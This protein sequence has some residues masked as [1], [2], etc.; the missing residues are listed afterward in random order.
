MGAV[1]QAP[2]GGHICLS[3]RRAPAERDR[4][5][6]VRLGALLEGIDMGEQRDAIAQQLDSAL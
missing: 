3:V 2:G 6:G 4:G 5:L 1:G